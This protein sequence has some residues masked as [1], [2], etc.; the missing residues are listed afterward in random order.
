MDVRNTII[1]SI[2][3]K[4]HTSTDSSYFIFNHSCKKE[5]KRRN[6]D[7]CQHC[8]DLIARMK[9]NDSLMKEKRKI[10]EVTNTK[11]ELKQLLSSNKKMK[12]K[13]VT[14][15]KQTKSLKRKVK[16][17][18]AKIEKLKKQVEN[19]LR[20]GNNVTIT[21]MNEVQKWKLL[22]ELAHERIKK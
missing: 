14:L 20:N 3:L 21:D 8:I 16:R 10:E 2:S 19:F 9:K 22:I 13:E 1:A 4:E 5:R 17:R 6:S 11:K 7:N 18:D 12:V 15:K